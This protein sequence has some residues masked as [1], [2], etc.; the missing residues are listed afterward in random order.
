MRKVNKILVPIDFSDESARALRHGWSLAMETHAELVALHAIE[1]TDDNFI[2]SVAMLEGSP[3]P[4]NEF[5][6]VPVDVVARERSLDLWNFIAQTVDVNNQIKIARKVRM[7]SLLK[8]MM[9]TIH[10]EEITLVV[11]KLR[12]GGMFFS[13]LKVLKLIKMIRRLPCPVLL[14]TSSNRYHSGPGKG[15]L[16]LQPVPEEAPA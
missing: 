7:G 1:K 2:A 6:T 12:E 10:E 13:A 15:L 3:L 5:P 8:A 14:D 9:A 11:I 4:I 16:W